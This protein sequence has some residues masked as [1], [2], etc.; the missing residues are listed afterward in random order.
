LAGDRIARGRAVGGAREA[1]DVDEHH[2]HLDLLARKRIGIVEHPA[3][4]LGIGVAA[5]RRVQRLTL[6]QAADHAIERARQVAELVCRDDGDGPAVVAALDSPCR[7][8]QLLDR[9]KDGR[10]DRRDVN[11]SD[12]QGGRD[13]DHEGRHEAERTIVEARDRGPHEC[14]REHGGGEESEQ[15]PHAQRKA[16]RRRRRR[17]NARAHGSEHERAQRHL[18]GEDRPGRAGRKRDH[19]AD[20]EGR[21]RARLEVELRRR[22]ERGEPAE[23]KDQRSG[24]PHDARR[25]TQRR[26]P[27]RG[28]AGRRL[29]RTGPLR[30]RAQFRPRDEQAECDG[31]QHLRLHHRE[32]A[33]RR[34]DAGVQVPRTG[35]DGRGAHG[36][37]AEDHR[38]DERGHI[39]TPEARVQTLE[40]ALHV[41]IIA[42]AVRDS[43][44]RRVEAVHALLPGCTRP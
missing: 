36:D 12:R 20:V 38:G 34:A 4:H 32:H 30:Q 33:R 16:A 6:A 35:G 7:R 28:G 25:Q 10:G 14:R 3:R 44:R 23:G 39:P 9:V 8:G 37:A 31:R 41:R 13:G 43:P 5:E 1:A 26:Q 18:T 42:D 19:R 24:R 22:V 40:P 17:G 27:G 11:E 21:R 2:G 29:A 15:R